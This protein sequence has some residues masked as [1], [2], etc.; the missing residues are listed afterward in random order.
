[1]RRGPPGWLAC[2]ASLL[3]LLAAVAV[4]D[5]VIRGAADAVVLLDEAPTLSVHKGEH[6]VLVALRCVPAYRLLAPNLS[7]L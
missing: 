5:P 1:M 4:S 6:V 7:S 3:C 2:W